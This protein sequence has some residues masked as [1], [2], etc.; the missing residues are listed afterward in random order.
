MVADSSPTSTRATCDVPTGA[1][2]ARGSGGPPGLR[3]RT[4]IGDGR[5]DGDAAGRVETRGDAW[6]HVVN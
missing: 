4:E 2:A 5:E 3:G 6:R 1:G